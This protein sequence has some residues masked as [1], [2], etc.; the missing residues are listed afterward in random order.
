MNITHF[1]DLLRAAAEQPQPQRLLFVFVATGLPDDATAEQGA[2]FQAGE[3]GTLTP[4]MC[5]DKAPDEL[6]SFETLADEAATLSQDWDL[7][8][9]A[10]LSGQ[11]GRGPSAVDAEL[12]LQNMIESI[13]AGRIDRYLTFDIQGLP[14]QFC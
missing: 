14:V 9:V 7:V 5:V 12:P 2:Q 4:L 13:N 3:G 11:D 1:N 6:A 8:F 10:A